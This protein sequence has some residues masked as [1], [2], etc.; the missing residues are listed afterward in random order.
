M[1]FTVARICG[2]TYCAADD[3]DLVYFAS[4]F[5]VEQFFEDVFAYSADA[6]NGK[7]PVGGFGHDGLEFTGK[8]RWNEEYRRR[9]G[10]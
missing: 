3:G 7:I 10:G 1:W 6:G 9:G 2:G 5:L 4:G 8:P